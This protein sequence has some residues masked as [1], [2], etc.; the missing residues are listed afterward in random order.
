MAYR[1]G[2]QLGTGGTVATHSMVKVGGQTWDGVYACH[3]VVDVEGWH[4]THHDCDTLGYCESC[5]SP[6]TRR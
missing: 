1:E 6:N 4:I 3:F 2:G 5:V